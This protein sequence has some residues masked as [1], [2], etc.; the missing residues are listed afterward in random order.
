MGEAYN[1]T[2][3]LLER[4]RAHPDRPVFRQEG[5][6]TTY[7]ALCERADRA[8]NALLRLGVQM[9]Q[10]VLLCMLDSPDFAAVFWGAM[11]AGLV[12]VPV[13][14]LLTT[15]DYDY[16]LRDS[17]ARVLVVS[18]ALLPKLEP[19]LRGQPFLSAVV[20]AGGSPGGYRVL[21]ELLAEAPPTLEPAPTHRD[22]VAFWLC[23]SGSTGPPKGA[24]HR[25]ADFAKPAARTA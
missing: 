18:A 24:M 12:P 6:V 9:E 1:A 14:T 21:D 20:V 8:G 19:I 16:L 7:G 25:L 2:V 3:D 23:S 17:R 5:R 13:N 15:A 11:K 10:R 22:D 4:N